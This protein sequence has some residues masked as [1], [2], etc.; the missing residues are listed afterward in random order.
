MP[1]LTL[2]HLLF[3]VLVLTA[4]VC[5]GCGNRYVNSDITDPAQARKQ[6]ADDKALCKALANDTVPPTYGME[7]YTDDPTIEAQAD[8]YVANV[9]EDDAHQGV[10]TRCM[11]DRGWQ[12]R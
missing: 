1:F 10:F 11:T 12:L 4:L 6:L 3:P 2:T 7:R 5:A 9:V 8:Q